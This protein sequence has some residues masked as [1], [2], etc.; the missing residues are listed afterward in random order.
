MTTPFQWIVDNAIDLSVNR[1][2]VVAQTVARDQTVRS[3][4]RGGQVWRFT[5]NPSQGILWTTARPYIES[6]DKADKFTASLINFSNNSGLSYLFGYQGNATSLAGMTT[7]YTQGSD[8]IT[9]SGGTCPSGSILKAG[10]LLQFAGSQRVYSVV[11]NVAYNGTSVQLNR[12]VLE[13]SSSGA[14]T[15]G[16]SCNF[17][18]ICTQFPDWTINP[19]DRCVKWNGPFVFFEEL[20]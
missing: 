12:P 19:D 6:L 2:A 1:R 13:V 8:T 9:I 5:I 16:A 20:A 3:T 15:V 4:S 11:S 7:T 17:N 10:D 18:I 14:L